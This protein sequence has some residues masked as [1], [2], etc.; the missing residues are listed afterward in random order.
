M[1][2]RSSVELGPGI[3]LQAANI[4][5]NVASSIHFRRTTISRRI[6]AACAAGPPKQP[7]LE[8]HSGDDQGSGP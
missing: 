2:L 5:R 3:R 8:Q 1:N 4:R 6:S 7:N